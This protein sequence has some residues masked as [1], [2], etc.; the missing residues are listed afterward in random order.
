MNYI[1]IVNVIEN[2][3]LAT[4]ISCPV[5]LILEILVEIAHKWRPFWNT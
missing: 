2:I 4:E 3:G 5:V 1:N